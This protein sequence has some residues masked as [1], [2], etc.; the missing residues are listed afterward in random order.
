MNIIESQEILERKKV[1]VLVVDDDKISRTLIKTMMM[2]NS[3]YFE[4]EIDEA[5]DGQEW[6]EKINDGDY[7]VVF[8]DYH[9]PRMNGIECLKWITN[10]NKPNVIMVTGAWKWDSE[11]EGVLKM[12]YEN[13]VYNYLAKPIQAF[14]VTQIWKNALNDAIQKREL[15]EKQIKLTERVDEIHETKSRIDMILEWFL[16]H[17]TIYIDSI[18]T[19]KFPL[20]DIAVFQRPYDRGSGDI[21]MHNK[22]RERHIHS[23]SLFDISGHSLET[24]VDAQHVKLLRMSEMSHPILNRPYLLEELV[25]IMNDKIKKA[26]TNREKRT[27]S[28]YAEVRFNMEKNILEVVNCGSEPPILIRKTWVVE[29]F[30]SQTLPLGMVGNN[31]FS[32]MFDNYVMKTRFE[33]WDWFFMSSDGLVEA[34]DEKG[35]KFLNVIQHI[36]RNNTHLWV[37]EMK[38]LLIKYYIEHTGSNTFGDDITFALMKIRD[39][40]ESMFIDFRHNMTYIKSQLEL[41]PFFEDIVSNEKITIIRDTLFTIIQDIYEHNKTTPGFLVEY[42]LL[43]DKRCVEV[44]IDLGTSAHN[45]DYIDGYIKEED[46]DKANILAHLIEK[47]DKIL[48]MKEWKKVILNFVY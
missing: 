14:S 38:Q 44:I 9:M 19:R 31:E 4:L 8:L 28:T 3:L 22:F 34:E 42:K 11:W 12:A 6:L 15:R 36:V 25:L 35:L 39:D 20:F 27:Y 17:E 48:V 13:E 41:T 2:K 16:S 46:S 24:S 43:P 10:P 30:K 1:K 21:F 23:F 45:I 29:K 26:F 37:E 40:Y 5:H 33:R 47:T 7:D 32:M 18:N